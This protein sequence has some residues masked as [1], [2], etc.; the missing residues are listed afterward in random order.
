[1]FMGTL[2]TPA[3][4]KCVRECPDGFYGDE[5][6]QECEECSTGCKTC[7][8]PEEDQCVRCHEGLAM[9]N[10]ECEAEQETCPDKTYLTGEPRTL[11]SYHKIFKGP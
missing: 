9:V 8:G 4:G 3:D 1:M 5:D 10:G 6:T 2:S 7:T 11:L